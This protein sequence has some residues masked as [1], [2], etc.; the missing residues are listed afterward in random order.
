MKINLPTRKRILLVFVILCLTLLACRLSALTT[1]GDYVKEYGGD[2][3]IYTHI[4][5]L[6]DCTELQREVER[7]DE[8]SKQQE[9]GTPEYKSFIGYKTAAENRIKEVE[10]KGDL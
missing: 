8:E 9:P 10:C 4:L 5:S 7:A 1:P 6:T 3:S 2:I